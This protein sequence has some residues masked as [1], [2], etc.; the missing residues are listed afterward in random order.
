[1]CR[2]TCF[3]PNGLTS[4]G[5]G[6]LWPRRST[7]LSAVMTATRRPGGI[8]DDLLAEQGPAP[9]LDH[10][11]LRVDLVGAVEVQVERLDLV[12]LAKRD[13][14]RSGELRGRRARRDADEPERLLARRARRVG[15]P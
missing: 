2:S 10:P 3:R 11:E 9:S 12:E 4:T 1:M 15:G 8:D 14:D 5:I 7:R 13:P 6:I